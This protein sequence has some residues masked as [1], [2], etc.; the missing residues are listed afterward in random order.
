MFSEKNLKIR[1]PQAPV[2]YYYYKSLAFFYYF[3]SFI[4]FFISLKLGINLIYQGLGIN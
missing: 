3:L 1:I 2:N 4:C